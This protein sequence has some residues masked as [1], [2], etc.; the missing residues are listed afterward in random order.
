MALEQEK[1]TNESCE[2]LKEMLYNTIVSI[3]IASSDYKKSISDMKYYPVLEINKDFRKRSSIIE[4]IAAKKRISELPCK[5]ITIDTDNNLLVLAEYTTSDSTAKYRFYSD[6]IESLV[7]SFRSIV[8]QIVFDSLYSKLS[9]K[10][11]KTTN[12]SFVL[13]AEIEYISKEKCALDISLGLVGSGKLIRD[14]LHIGKINVPLKLIDIELQDKIENTIASQID[15]FDDY[16]DTLY[17]NTVES[18]DISK[19]CFKNSQQILYQSLD[20]AYFGNFR[21]S[22]LR[23]ENYSSYN[24]KHA[25]V[26]LGGQ[27]F[28]VKI[29][30]NTDNQHLIGVHITKVRFGFQHLWIKETAYEVSVS[31][32]HDEWNGNIEVKCILEASTEI[33]N[34]KLKYSMSV[35]DLLNGIN[36]FDKSIAFVDAKLKEQVKKQ[37]D[38][39]TMMNTRFIIDSMLVVDR[40]HTRSNEP[41]AL[42]LDGSLDAIKIKH[43]VDKMRILGKSIIKLSD[44]ACIVVGTDFV[45]IYWEK[46]TMLK[47]LSSYDKDSVTSVYKFICAC[48][49]NALRIYGVDYLLYGGVNTTLVDGSII[50]TKL[51]TWR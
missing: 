23:V 16:F 12:D 44:K 14:S 28:P 40:M 30:Y 49:Q 20:I 48:V 21:S 50:E 51:V 31:I 24:Y 1:L 39:Y 4:D 3:K 46:G 33:Y 37:K 7:Q 29:P 38:R 22:G 8:V 27:L 25:T 2:K 35:Q 32:L 26:M 19:D 36:I 11:L 13:F 17:K 15:T 47:F 41:V 9:S 10:K 6:Y 45:N 5:L 42:R 43:I 34:T 18:N